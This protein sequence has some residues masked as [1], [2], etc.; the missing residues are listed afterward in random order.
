VEGPLSDNVFHVVVRVLEHRV[1]DESRGSLGK[2]LVLS[3]DRTEPEK[4]IPLFGFG[5]LNSVKE[6]EPAP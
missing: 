3:N 6:E 1:A 4:E 5:K 2:V